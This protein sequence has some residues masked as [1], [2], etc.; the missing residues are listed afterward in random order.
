V[1]AEHTYDH[2]FAAIFA[3]I[4]LDGPHSADIGEPR[5]PVS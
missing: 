3:R 1:R 4:G 2:R 5:L